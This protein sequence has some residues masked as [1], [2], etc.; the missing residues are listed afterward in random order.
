MQ[1]DIHEFDRL[2]VWEL[3]PQPDCVLTIALKWIY[4]V[5]LDGYGDVLKKK[6]RLVAKGYRQEGGIDFEEF[7]AP[8]ARI[9]AIRIFI[10][11][12]A[13]KNMTI[14]QMDVKTTFLNGELKEEVYVCQPE[15]FVDPDHP[16]HVYRLKKAMYG[17]KQA[18]R[19]LGDKLVSWSLKKQKST[20]IST[21]KAKYIAMSGSCSRILWMRSQLTDYGVAFNKIPLYCD[22]RSVIAIC[23]NNV[24]H[25]WSKY[26]DIRHHFIREQVEKKMADENIPAPA[27]TRSDDQILPFAAW[28]FLTDKANLG[29]PTKKGRKDKPYVIPYCRFTKLI[30]CHLV[31]THNIHQRS[32]SLFHLAE[33]D[34]KLGNLKFVPKGEVGEVFGMPIPNELISKNIRNAPYYGAYLEMVAKHDRKIA[35]EKE[36]KKKPTTA[37]QP[38]P[39]PAKEKSNKPAPASKPKVTKEKPFKPS[40]TKKKMKGEGKDQ[41]GKRAIQMSLE[42]CQ[43]QGQAHVGGVAIREPVVE[44]TRPLP[45]VEGNRKAIATDD[46]AA[47]SLLAMHAPKRRSIMD[48]FIFHSGGD[49]EI[50]QIDEGKEKDVDNQARPDPRVSRVALTRPNPEPM[51]KEFM[52][53]V[54]P[55]VHESLKFPGKLNVDSEVVS[56]VT[57]PIH[58]ASSSVPP[59]S[60]PVID[61]SP[62][63]PVSFTTQTP[64]FIATTTTTT[65]T[66]PLPPPPQQQQSSTDSEVHIALQAPVRDRFRELPKADMKEILHQQMFESGSYKSLPRHV[67]LYKALEASME[68]ANKDEFLVEKDKSRKR[69]RDYQDPPP[70]P[71]DSDLSKKKR[72]DL[73]T[74]GSTQPPAPHSSAWK[75]YDTQETPSCS[76]RQ[77]SASH[78]EQLI[79]D[80]PIP[81][82]VNVSDSEDPDTARLP[83]IKT[84]P[85]WLKLVSKEDRPITPEPKWVIPPNELPEPENN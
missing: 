46:Q 60:T 78:S 37:K 29:S 73:G 11:N 62:S 5:N 24:Q 21:T 28:T 64:I 1:D 8:I 83:K 32:A 17:L 77:K 39:K 31:R 14:Y 25:S 35:A 51:H 67:A 47:Q 20:A 36:G 65:T 63:K 40:P 81:D 55:D 38:K 45:V 12:A 41:D 53:N 13:N 3:V 33:E 16:T 19:F 52:A 54:Y 7:F 82:D 75:T 71:P 66:L 49:T 18:P 9:E 56:M 43:A 80:V 85:D 15:D 72:H 79:K 68:W 10:T 76:S 42:S 58:Q 26:I 70:P 61:L 30:I 84:K 27:P 23:Y 6:A 59:I 34:L 48:Q 57:V 2:Q 4:K 69:R 44:T 22:N 74:S 50:L